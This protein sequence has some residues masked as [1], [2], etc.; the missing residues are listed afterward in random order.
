MASI[1]P[2]ADTAA[3]PTAERGNDLEFRARHSLTVDPNAH[4][5]LP[6]ADARRLGAVA[7]GKEG[8]RTVIAVADPAESRLAALRELTGPSTT[9]VLIAPDALNALL[10]S[11]IFSDHATP[12][13]QRAVPAPPGAAPEPEQ[14][15]E[16]A[17][18]PEPSSVDDPAPQVLELETIET[19]APP[20]EQKSGEVTRPRYKPQPLPPPRTPVQ[21]R[22]EARQ[23]EGGELGELAGAVA[24]A[25]TLLAT[26]Q[27]RIAEFS[28]QLDEARQEVA[29][30]RQ[31]VEEARQEAREH[32]ERLAALA[33]KA[34]QDRA[35]V[36]SFATGLSKTFEGLEETKAELLE[37]LD[38]E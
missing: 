32:K 35:R 8:G 22:R 25:A 12:A 15:E 10:K 14:F 38:E 30:A 31:E 36:R 13:E 19:S 18:P 33:A 2:A 27:D 11:R 23:A 20:P 16:A 5:L 3:E 34:D 24:G 26:L 28:A 1:T 7:L 4:T 21:P 9:F 29:E 37:L 17:A 6:I